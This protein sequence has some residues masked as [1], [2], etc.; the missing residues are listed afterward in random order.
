MNSNHAIETVMN[1]PIISKLYRSVCV[2]ADK[3]VMGPM[4][5]QKDDAPS[6]ATCP[7]GYT[8]THCQCSISQC[9]GAI[10]SSTFESC[11]VYNANSRNKVQAQIN[12]TRYNSSLVTTSLTRDPLS[13]FGGQFHTITCPTG[14]SGVTCLFGL[15]V[16]MSSVLLVFLCYLFCEHL[17]SAW[18]VE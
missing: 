8:L 9:D 1:K 18:P 13:G 14:Q 7:S 16:T 5:L 15:L 12:C 3:V 2:S 4:S 6:K 11:T 17:F 10:I